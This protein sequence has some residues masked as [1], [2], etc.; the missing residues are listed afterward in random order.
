MLGLLWTSL[1]HFLSERSGLKDTEESS[2]RRQRKFCGAL[3]FNSKF[4]LI[5]LANA[6]TINADPNAAMT[7]DMISRGT[8]KVAIEDE[9]AQRER[10][11]RCL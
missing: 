2:Q 11:L 6:D 5:N 10:S 4:P 3:T 9:R 8:E 1:N 7:K